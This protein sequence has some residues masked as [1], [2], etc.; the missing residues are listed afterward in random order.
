MRVIAG[1]A[2]GYV[3]KKP[4]GN[5]IRPTADRVKEALFNIIAPKIKGAVV[6]DLFAGTGALG[7]EA[8]S[9]GAAKA[10]FIDWYRESIK[11]IHANLALTGLSPRATVY[12]LNI[13]RPQ[14][15][16]LLKSKG[17]L[18]NLVFLDPPYGKEITRFT[19]ENLAESGLLLPAGTVV[20]EHS[21]RDELPAKILTLQL[22]QRRHYGDTVLS[23]Y[24]KEN[25]T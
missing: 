23:F 21:P 9:R 10:V 1:R 2:R 22:G 14:S 4:R 16:N 12:R 19:L 24:G 6:L 3:L 13:H 20:V 5:K 18:F 17:L 15:L 25:N 11:L 7:I 8:L